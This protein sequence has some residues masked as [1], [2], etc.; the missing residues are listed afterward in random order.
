MSLLDEQTNREVSRQIRTESVL[1]ENLVNCYGQAVE[2]P[3]TQLAV[4]HGWC[5]LAAR[6]SAEGKDAASSPALWGLLDVE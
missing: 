6:N 4:S 2:K 1:V 3:K 5:I